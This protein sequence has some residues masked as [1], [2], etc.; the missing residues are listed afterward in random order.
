M[1]EDIKQ[2]IRDFITRETGRSVT[3]AD[4]ES[5]FSPLILDSLLMTKLLSFLEQRFGVVIDEGDRDDP[6][7]FESITGIASLVERARG[8]AW[9]S[10]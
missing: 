7:N 1:G 4:H 8:S 6:D 2:T 9:T 10:R 3:V 5:L